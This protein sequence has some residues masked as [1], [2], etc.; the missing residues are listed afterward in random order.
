M[1]GHGDLTKT[2]SICRYHTFRRS[3]NVKIPFVDQSMLKV[4][5]VGEMRNS[6]TNIIGN[7]IVNKEISVQ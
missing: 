1:L 7:Y 4:C 6:T 2:G 3:I 5:Y